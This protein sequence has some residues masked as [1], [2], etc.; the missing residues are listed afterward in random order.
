MTSE[1]LSGAY[2]AEIKDDLGKGEVGKNPSK[3]IV[4]GNALFY[5]RSCGQEENS[6]EMQEQN[7]VKCRIFKNLD[8]TD[9]LLCM[10]EWS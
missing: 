2:T 10:L 6:A 5:C 9:H 1:E 8:E 4:S 3:V 7:E